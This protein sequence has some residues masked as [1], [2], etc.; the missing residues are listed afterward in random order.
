MYYRT[1]RKIVI[2]LL[3]GTLL[4]IGVALL[5]LPGP[6]SLTILAGLGVLAAEFAWARLWLRKLKKQGKSLWDQVRGVPK[7]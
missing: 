5:V 6:G 1:A 3:G 4:L 2:A 7:C